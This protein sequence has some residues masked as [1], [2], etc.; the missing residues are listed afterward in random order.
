MNRIAQIICAHT[1][2]LTMTPVYGLSELFSS[3][4][5]NG[6][7]SELPYIGR[8]SDD[9]TPLCGNLSLVTSVTDE[10]KGTLLPACW[11]ESFMQRIHHFVFADDD[12][13][14]VEVEEMG[15]LSETL[16]SPQIVDFL[17]DFIEDSKR[18]EDLNCLS[19]AYIRLVSNRDPN[20]LS[21]IILMCCVSNDF[22]LQS[23][24]IDLIAWHPSIKEC[25][26]FLSFPFRH[27]FLQ[28]KAQAALAN[29]F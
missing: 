14:E 13:L 4:N 6:S 9:E 23:T 3:T 25:R 15:A 8:P 1:I 27:P 29:Q 5:D 20:V 24:G 11:Q 7:F 17:L 10:E 28:R 18:K 2:A 22:Q 26:V 16:S 21:R 12:E 19:S